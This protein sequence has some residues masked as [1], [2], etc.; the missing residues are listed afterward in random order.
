MSAR[1]RKGKRRPRLVRAHSAR[2]LVEKVGTTVGYFPPAVEVALA[3]SRR[4]LE[5]EQFRDSIRDKFSHLHLN[6]DEGL[7]DTALRLLSPDTVAGYQPSKGSYVSFAFATAS[8]VALEHRKRRGKSMASISEMNEAAWRGESSLERLE[9]AERDAAIRG[10][11]AQLSPKLNEVVIH[12]YFAMG[13]GPDVAMTPAQCCAHARAL[14]TL[15][16]LIDPLIE[17]TRLRNVSRRRTNGSPHDDKAA[18][19]RQNT[20][21]E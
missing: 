14:E 17:V 4:L 5:N 3:A 19:A 20:C 8:Y 21:T 18:R 15:Q 7:Q 2:T 1:T 16:G 11:V 10:A 9:N 6:A 12:R 13:I